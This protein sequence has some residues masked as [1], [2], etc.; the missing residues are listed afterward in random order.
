[1]RPIL[2]A[3]LAIFFGFS[4][5][6]CF[7][8]A[9]LSQQCE[10]AQVTPGD[11]V[12]VTLV[13]Q[14]GTLATKDPNMLG[15]G[16]LSL[17]LPPV[18]GLRE[19]NASS[20]V[21]SVNGA[22]T[23]TATFVVIPTHPGDYTIPPFDIHTQEGDVLHSKEMK[24][25]VTGDNTDTPAANSGT[26]SVT[27]D[28]PA[29]NSAGP[30]V[31][32][33][34]NSAAD[35]PANNGTPANTAGATANVPR[36]PDG[37]PAKVFILIT[38]QTTDAYVGQSI[39]MRIDFFIRMEV[40]A[41]Q[42]SLPTIKG[43][44]FL[45]NSFT[46]HG[47]QTLGMLEGREYGRE[48]WL[49]A[50]SA[51]Q[52]GD[53]P[54]KMVR[55]TYWIKSFSNGL[56]NPFSG[57]PTRHANLAHDLIYSNEIT[58]H[59]N[60]LPMQGQ[61]DHFTGAIGQF[62]ITGDARPT[63][64]A[65]G[66][67]V[68]LTFSVAGEGNF[69]YVRCPALPDAPGWK[70]Y[71]PSAKTAYRNESHTNAVKTFQQSII[72]QKNG[73]LQLPAAIFIYFDPETKQY[74]NVPIA[75]PEITVTGSLAPA[76][77]ESSGVTDNSAEISSTT[78]ADEFL[79]NQL[80]IGSLQTH[81]APAYR[82]RWFWVVQIGLVALPFL[83]FGFFY[84]QSRTVPNHSQNERALLLLSQQQE[85]EAMT[86]AVRQN[87]PHAFFLAARH[88][89]QLQLGAQWKLSPEAITLGEVRRRDAQLAETLEPLFAQ[90]D[91]VIYSGRTSSGID[92]AQWD[93]R[94]RTEFLQS[95]PA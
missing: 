86:E 28:G 46:T 79:P 24:F 19:G 20:S 81:L 12:T 32:P 82:E 44:D 65:V 87:D 29:T 57:M 55:D 41:D 18:D 22:T 76:A 68:T 59:V 60:P 52:A 7:A 93:H 8:E 4:S 3:P 56:Y 80:E 31:M 47:Q 15:L 50:I 11:A 58:M 42:N 63:S 25:Q 34:T 16:N 48:T 91:E 74:V 6:A 73:N 45:M 10:P 72:P 69:D 43:S 36:D 23:T 53:F 39:P 5:I 35:Q 49:T 92:L 40:N 26:V 71:V 61:P 38:P 66:E 2:L 85:E 78:T 64:V 21:M 70:A 94:V 67:P 14:G 51:P 62:Q 89:I 1:M 88:A 77:S 33:P 37:S 75:L 27:A 84:L 9:T 90:A 95:Q 83:G 30:V 54:L 13:V 17:T